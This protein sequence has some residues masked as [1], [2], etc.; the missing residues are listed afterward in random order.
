[1]CTTQPTVTLEN[2]DDAADDAVTY[3]LRLDVNPCF[4]SEE[5]MQDRLEEGHFVTQWTVPQPL[6]IEPVG[7]HTTFYIERWAF[8]GTDQSPH[9]LSLF[10]VDPNCLVDPS[11]GSSRCRWARR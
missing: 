1:V 3:W 10:E 7:G 4:C 8:D 2:V 9:E 11:A 5:L 6:N